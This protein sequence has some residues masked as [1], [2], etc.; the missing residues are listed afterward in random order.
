MMTRKLIRQ[1][2][3]SAGILVISSL[4]ILL[5]FHFFIKSANEKINQAAL[6]DQLGSYIQADHYELLASDI[7]SKHPSIK[8]VYLAKDKDGSLLG[9]IVDVEISDSKG[10]LSTRMSISSNGERILKL[11]IISQNGE[12]TD[13]SEPV[14]SDLCAQ[15]SEIRMPVALTSQFSTDIMT[16]NEY[17]ALS[18]L[19]DGIFYA[20]LEDFD[21]RGYKDFVEMTVSGG[22]ITQI[23]WDAVEKDEGKNRAEASVDGEYEISSD[24][25]IWA[26][27]AYAIQNK[28]IEVQDPAKL[29]I[30]SDGI[31]EI[32]EGVEMDVRVFYLLTTMC[33]ENS[34]NNI[35]KGSD[36]SLEVGSENEVDTDTEEVDSDGDKETDNSDETQQTAQSDITNSTTVASEPTEPTL[37]P[38]VSVVGNEDGVV[39]SDQNNILTESI[40]GLPL[41]EIQTQ[42]NGIEEDPKL[43]ERTVSTVNSAYKFLREFLKW[44]A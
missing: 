2:A 25:Q 44:G 43:S 4:V 42:I 32:V 3:I 35:Q 27:Q 36:P 34:M 6:Y 9:Y 13:M 28:L 17:P 19:H 22:R 14:V 33:I 31:T 15:F 1:F 39:D 23:V 40:D 30:K 10:T 37:T 24:Q 7:L 8:S 18:G 12:Q 16:Q 5:T 41:T 11:N 29:A 38:E 21:K 20:S 26:A